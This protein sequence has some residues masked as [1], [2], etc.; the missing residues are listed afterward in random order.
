VFFP[1]YEKLNFEYDDINIL[2]SLKIHIEGFSTSAT[3][4]LINIY[5]NKLFFNITETQR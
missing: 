5:K 2:I 1:A 3:I 4:Y